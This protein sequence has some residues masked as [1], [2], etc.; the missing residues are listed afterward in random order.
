MREILVI[1]MPLD[2]GWW[3]LTDVAWREK[4]GSEPWIWSISPSGHIYEGMVHRS[5]GQ[6]RTTGGDT[7]LILAVS[8]P[9]SSPPRATTPLVRAGACFLL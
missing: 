4:D 6:Q 1:A 3:Q 5:E 2:H 9:P 7:G 8:S